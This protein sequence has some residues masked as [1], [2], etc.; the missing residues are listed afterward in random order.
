MNV[1][2]AD[3]VPSVAVKPLSDVGLVVKDGGGALTVP[4]TESVA[5][6]ASV[7]ATVITPPLKEPAGVAAAMRISMEVAA[8]VPLT[9][10]M[11][12]EGP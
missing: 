5:G 1:C 12:V 3:A 11:V 8:T 2:G 6:V 10:D 9:G 7:L 4:E